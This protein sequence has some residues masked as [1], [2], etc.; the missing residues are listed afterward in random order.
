MV[1]SKP[2][3]ALL[4]LQERTSRKTLLRAMPCRT[5]AQTRDTIRKTIRAFPRALR[6]SM[7]FDNGPEFYFHHHLTDA[8]GLQSYFCDI[9][10]PWQK[11]GVENQIGRLRR[12]LPRKTHLPAMTH[13]EIAKLQNRIN[14]TP[15]KRLDFKTPDEAFSKLIKNVALQM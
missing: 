4:V 11:G 6:R 14:Q 8:I 7:T 13:T 3:P 2:G 1:F 15:R 9:R 5:A 12:F 10:S